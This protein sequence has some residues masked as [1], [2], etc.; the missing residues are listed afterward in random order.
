[1]TI[2]DV[3]I[4]QGGRKFVSVTLNRKRTTLAVAVERKMG[5]HDSAHSL[6][7]RVFAQVG[8]ISDI[9]ERNSCTAGKDHAA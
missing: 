1:M 2:M 5:E 3:E 4:S 6:L 8:P 7:A 9:A